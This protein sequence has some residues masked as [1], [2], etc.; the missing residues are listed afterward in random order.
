LNLTLVVLLFVTL[1][2]LLFVPLF[3]DAGGGGAVA[4]TAGIA[5]TASIDVTIVLSVVGFDEPLP[6]PQ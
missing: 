1:V 2:V 5:A 6:L 3:P 4:A